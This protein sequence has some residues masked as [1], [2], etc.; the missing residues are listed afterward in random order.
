MLKALEKAVA[1]LAAVAAIIGGMALAF[2]TGVTVISVFWR[3][4]LR[5][6]IFGIE[7]LST[8]SLVVLVACAIVWSATRGGHVSVDLL[9]W[10]IGRKGMRFT[11]VLARGLSCGMLLVASYALFKKGACGM[12]CGAMTSNL[13]I[14]HTPYYYALGIAMAIFGALMALQLVAGL[15]AWNTAKDPN[16]IGD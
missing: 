9:G 12:P 4:A 10:F 13:S 5:D 11:D 2:L 15:M 14:I 1:F 6:P 7:D 16:P 3:Y 8:M